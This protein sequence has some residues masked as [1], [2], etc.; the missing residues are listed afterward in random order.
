[1]PDKGGLMSEGI[2]TLVPVP[3]KSD[4]NF[5]FP[6]LNSKELIQIFC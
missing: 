3:T 5:E 4:R 6:A 2:L 1:M